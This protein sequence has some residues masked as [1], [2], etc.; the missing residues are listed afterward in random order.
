[1]YNNDERKK[2]IKNP[3]GLAEDWFNGS[4]RLKG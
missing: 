3:P 1:M 2:Q 4:V